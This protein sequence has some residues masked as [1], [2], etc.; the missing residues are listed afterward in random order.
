MPNSDLTEDVR[1]GDHDN[2]AATAGGSA[3][4]SF[5]VNVGLD[6]ATRDRL[7]REAIVI[8]VSPTE[9]ARRCIAQALMDGVRYRRQRDV[10]SRM[11]RRRSHMDF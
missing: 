9:V 10:A 8:G 2:S 11:R 6:S 3:G 7:F 1:K 4:G 5:R